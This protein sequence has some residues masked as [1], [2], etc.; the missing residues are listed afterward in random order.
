MSSNEITVS[1]GSR[2]LKLPLEIRR[3]LYGLH[4]SASLSRPSH[5][6]CSNKQI[7]AEARD[8]FYWRPLR[9]GSQY[10]LIKYVASWPDNVLR[11]ITNLQLH[12]EG[13][14]YEVMQD[15]FTAAL[16]ANHVGARKYPYL[17]EINQFT[18]ALSRLASITHLQILRP[19]HKEKSMPSSIVM[20]QVLKWMAEHYPKLQSLRLDVEQCHIDCL[21][22]FAGLKSLRLTGNSETSAVRTG[23]ILGKLSNLEELTI[24]GPPQALQTLRR[25]GCQTKIVQAVTHQ[26]LERLPPLKRLTLIEK[27]VAKTDSAI[28]LT[29]RT[30]KA[31]YEIHQE[32]LRALS[33][34]SSTLPPATF[35]QFLAAFLLGTPNIEELSLT[36]PNLA[37]TFVDCIPNSV[38]RLEL[39]VASRGKAQFILDRLMLMAYRLR[40][41]QVIKFHIINPVHGTSV[42]D[43]KNK[44]SP[45]T[46]SLP[47]QSPSE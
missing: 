18:L 23:D 38:Q 37:M 29:T 31:L 12:V 19:A 33:I 46:I 1:G 35:V 40:Y 25:H 22:S 27:T 11:S 7:H 16:S 17:L 47:I 8:S 13:I 39:A 20:T 36:W 2:F 42:G 30:I 44:S 43:R 45:L 5:L 41:L 9:C 15:Y 34:S 26:V 28:Y 21:G 14:R 10:D 4:A 24:T 32:S 3:H 6:L